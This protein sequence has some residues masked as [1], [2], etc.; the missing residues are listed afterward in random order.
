M[1]V[2]ARWAWTVQRH[3]Q[4]AAAVFSVS[5]LAVRTFRQLIHVTRFR[6]S[7]TNWKCSSLV[8]GR[9]EQ[10]YNIYGLSLEFLKVLKEFQFLG[11]FACGRQLFASSHPSVRPSAG[12]RRH[13]WAIYWH[14]LP[15][16]DTG[17]T[18]LCAWRPTHVSDISQWSRQC[19]LCGTNS[20][21]STK[22]HH[23]VAKSEISSRRLAIQ[24]H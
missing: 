19:F 4:L 18:R 23:F 12:T 13:I 7:T 8:H 24:F 20:D 16:S 21:C 6:P 10:M 15:Y 11:A 14:A 9:S 2:T 17:Q 5:E 22:L 3:T 1:S